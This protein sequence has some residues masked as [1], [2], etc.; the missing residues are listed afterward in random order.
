MDSLFSIAG[1]SAI[2]SALQGLERSRDGLQ[3]AADEVLAATTQA[4]SGT[5]GTAD[6]VSISDVARGIGSGSLE[7]G[8]LGANTAKLTYQ[9]NVAVIRTADEQLQDML[10]LAVPNSDRNA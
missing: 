2:D 9:M 8:L 1:S 6:T 7:N 4:V 5:S 3:G 10:D